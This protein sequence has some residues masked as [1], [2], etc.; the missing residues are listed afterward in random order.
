MKTYVVTYIPGDGGK[1]VCKIMTGN[2]V[3]HLYGFSDCFGEEI[4]HVW[5]ISENGDLIP[6]VI[7]GNF[8]APMNIL[9]I[10]RLGNYEPDQYEWPEH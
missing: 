8:H 10:H 5:E 7:W 4:K 3:A 6:C 2:D 1:A 9:N